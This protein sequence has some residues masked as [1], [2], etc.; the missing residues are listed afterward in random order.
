[1]D[2]D[3]KH[4]PYLTSNG[5]IPSHAGFL[6]DHYDTED[7]SYASPKDRELA[8]CAEGC[9]CKI[10]LDEEKE[11]RELYVCPENCRCKICV[12]A[13]TE[14][15]AKSNGSIQSGKLSRNVIST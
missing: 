9:R 8:V 15:L 13:E 2:R 14:A 7:D 10:C 12:N 5:D 3:N 4:N 1:M 11:A 6:G